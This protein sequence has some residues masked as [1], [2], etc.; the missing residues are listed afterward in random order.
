[1]TSMNKTPQSKAKYKRGLATDG[2]LSTGPFTSST[3]EGSAST[4]DST[5]NRRKV[6]RRYSQMIKNGVPQYYDDAY[7]FFGRNATTSA[8]SN[9]QSVTSAESNVVCTK[10]DVLMAQITEMRM[11]DYN[12]WVLQIKTLE[13]MIF[14]KDNLLTQFQM[15]NQRLEEAL[16]SERHKVVEMQNQ[17][18]KLNQRFQGA[19]SKIDQK[20]KLLLEKSDSEKVKS[21]HV[22]NVMQELMESLE[23]SRK[24]ISELLSNAQEDSR[25]IISLR[26]KNRKCTCSSN[27][28][29]S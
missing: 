18:D 28:N 20:N 19:I 29:E 21:M 8:E 9:K 26:S 24:K 14:N 5:N 7:G 6:Y 16:A 23:N 12:K 3:S 10:C 17:M 13:D 15:E 11:K 4:I 25:T 27:K 1:M 2:E 22:L